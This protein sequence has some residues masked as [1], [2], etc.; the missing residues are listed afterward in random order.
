MAKDQQQQQQQIVIGSEKQITTEK[1]ISAAFEDLKLAIAALAALILVNHENLREL[2]IEEDL[3]LFESTPGTFKARQKR[4]P[5][6]GD[7][8]FRRLEGILG[9]LDDGQFDLLHTVDNVAFAA[10]QG[11]L[12]AEAALERPREDEDEDED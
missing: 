3:G 11:N 6:R 8:A 9:N 5:L 12:G 4:F 10:K 1:G 2:A 7:P